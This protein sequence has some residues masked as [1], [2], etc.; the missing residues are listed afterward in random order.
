MRWPKKPE[1]DQ[2]AQ[3]SRDELQK[4]WR[5][6]DDPSGYFQGGRRGEYLASLAKQY[7]KPDASIL[8]LGCNVGSNLYHL[9]KA[10]YRNLSGVEIN[11]QALKLMKQNFPDMQVVIYEGSIEDRIKELAEYDLVFTIAVLEHIHRDSEWAFP[12]IAKRARMLI[13][14]EGEKGIASELHIARN[15]KSI[16]EG[17]GLQQV[18]E[19][20][21][22]R[23]EG[24]N[25][26]FYARVFSRN[27]S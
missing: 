23:E 6:S 15:Y 5:N 4:H 13:T 14:I 1:P 17:L 16:F 8:E 12:E 18:Y 2:P 27:R 25:A 26:N 9:W 24:L 22:G 10:G 7:A 21:L 3:K 19:K 11:P 20:N